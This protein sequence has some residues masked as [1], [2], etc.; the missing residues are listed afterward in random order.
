MP[1]QST[2]PIVVDGVNFVKNTVKVASTP[3]RAAVGGLLA[4][5][6]ASYELGG[7]ARRQGVEAIQGGNH[8]G[9]A[10]G[11][12]RKHFL[13]CLKRDAC[14]VDSPLDAQRF[15]VVASGHR[16]RWSDRSRGC[17]S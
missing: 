4:V 14:A 11:V 7:K 3:V 13:G 15:E 16:P 5:G 1:I 10:V 2:N 12:C 17:I 6:E 9:T 8:A